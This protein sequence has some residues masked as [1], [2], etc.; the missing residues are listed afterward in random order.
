[1]TYRFLGVHYAFAVGDNITTFTASEARRIA[2]LLKDGPT[3]NKVAAIRL[4]R[5]INGWSLKDSKDLVDGM[6]REINRSVGQ[7]ASPA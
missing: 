1:M 2:E 7:P 5:D 4:V 3:M 6:E